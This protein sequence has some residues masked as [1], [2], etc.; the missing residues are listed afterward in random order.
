TIKPYNG[1]VIK[2]NVGLSAEDNN[3]YKWMP[4]FD[5]KGKWQTVV[6]PLTEVFAEYNPKPVVNPA[7]YW[8]R[9]LAGHSAGDW[10]ADIAFDNLRVVPKVSK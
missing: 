3:G 6:I 5:T 4:P 1:N 2:I 10:D 7:G 9:L 8:S